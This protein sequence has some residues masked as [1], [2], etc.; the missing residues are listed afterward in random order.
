VIVISDV[1][2]KRGGEVLFEHLDLTLHP[3][4]RNAIVGRNGVGKSSLFALLRGRL[5]PEVGDVRI[6]P[7]WRIAHLD[8]ETQASDR[9][10]LEWA[11]DGDR[12]L[13]RVQRERAD[14]ERRGDNA[15]LARLHVEFDD[16]GGYTAEARA[17]EILDGLGFRA[18]EFG[19]PYAEFSGGWR[20]RLNLAQTLMC[21]SDLLLLDEPTNHLDLD[22]MLWLE[23]HLRRYEGTLLV[24]AHDREFLDAIADHTVHLEAGRATT[25]RGNYSSFERQRGENLANQAALARRQARKAAE[26]MRFVDR[27]RAKSSKARQV[28]SRLKALERLEVAMPA[29]VDSPYEFTFPNPAQMSPLLIQVDNATLG[30]PDARILTVE[31][32]RV[33]PG[34]RIGVLGAN[35]AGK[36]T[37]MRTLAGDLAPLGGDVHRGQHSSVGYFAQHQLELLDPELGA[38]AHLRRRT[39]PTTDQRRR[40]YLGGWGFPGDMALRPTATLSGGEKARLV[41]A[42]IAWEQPAILMLD[43]PTNHLDIEMRHALT[44]ALQ[45]YDGAM[46]IVSHDRDLLGRCV[47]EFWLVADGTVQPYDDDLEHYADR[48][49]SRLRPVAAPATAGPTRRAQRQASA[50][51]RRQTQALR[52][53][54]KTLEKKIESL[55]VTVTELEIR[56]ADPATYETLSTAQLQALIAQRNER[57]LALAAA[58][59]EWLEAY[60]HLDAITAASAND[61]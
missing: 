17:A 39:P 44:V 22:A 6:P 41:L 61:R 33:G 32:L 30:Y 46:V 42:L 51:Q 25:Y 53:A 1:T 59:A 21:P 28:Q 18:N 10:A 48:I 11:M 35:G 31:S 15:A 8:Q 45:A 34:A 40:D 9:S 19:K 57:K 38:L 26:I 49:R 36:T 27:F 43:E 5:L 7:R 14:A 55:G 4:H 20:I 60:E 47:D 29:H 24:I 54:V 50:E 2:L 23:G 58:E 52:N 3:G 13:R 12:H 16:L 37:L 56:L